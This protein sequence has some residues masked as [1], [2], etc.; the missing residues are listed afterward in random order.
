[1]SVRTRALALSTIAALTAGALSVPAASAESYPSAGAVPVAQLDINQVDGGLA[2]V[3]ATPVLQSHIDTVTR[4]LRELRARAWDANLPLNGAS[5]RDVA[6]DRTAYINGMSWSRGLEHVALQRAAEENFDFDH[7]R[8]GGAEAW[9]AKPGAFSAE[10]LTSTT[11][12][13]AIANW[14]TDG[15]SNSEWNK[16]IRSNGYF[17]NGT[18]HLHNMLNPDNRY[19]AQAQVGNTT[20]GHYSTERV[21]GAPERLEGRHAF[22]IAVPESAFSRADIRFTGGTHVG[23]SGSIGLSISGWGGA[24]LAVPGASVSSSNPEVLA[25]HPDGTYEALQEGTAELSITPFLMR[26]GKTRPSGEAISQTVKVSKKPAIGGAA[27]GSSAGAAI[28]IIAVIV[29]VLGIGTQVLRYM[30][31]WQ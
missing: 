7:Q 1:M 22:P 15:G 4:Q 21:S 18:G 17:T 25:V 14:S 30:G 23:D 3:Y 8:A 29:A 27:G 19:F 2:Y 6:P 16:L 24:R 28:G 20:A 11:M 10:N 13:E 31:L 5:L 9:T 26:N 12:S